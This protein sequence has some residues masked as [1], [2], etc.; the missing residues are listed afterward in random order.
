M[1]TVFPALNH[2]TNDLQIVPENCPRGV[3]AMRHQVLQQLVGEH[4][5]SGVFLGQKNL[6]T[7]SNTPVISCDRKETI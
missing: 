1:E 6:F 3:E 2:G 5:I 4:F 7:N